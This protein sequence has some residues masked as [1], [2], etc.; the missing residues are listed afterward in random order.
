MNS[1]L[2]KKDNKQA[3]A[4]DDRCWIEPRVD[5]LENKDEW[6]VVADVPGVLDK[7]LNVH[8]EKDELTLEAGCNEGPAAGFPYAG[9]RRAFTLP[10]GVDT[11]KVTAE[12]K[13]GV[14]SVHLPKA[15]ALSPRQIEVH[16]G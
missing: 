7:G 11:E 16:A 2:S 10:K 6:L 15:A 8:L 3:R 9:Y 4:V 12:L 14:I 5:V 13:K 1:E